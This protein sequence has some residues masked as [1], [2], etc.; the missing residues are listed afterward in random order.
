MV[1]WDDTRSEPA[2]SV[3]RQAPNPAL[4]PPPAR[5]RIVKNKSLF[6]SN[7]EKAREGG[8]ICTSGTRV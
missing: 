7:S 1:T 5:N 8:R 2:R 3:H 4:M 6:D